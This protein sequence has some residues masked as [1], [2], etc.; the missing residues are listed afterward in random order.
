MAQKQAVLFV[1][2]TKNS[3]SIKSFLR[4]FFKKEALG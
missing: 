2:G 4:L 3:H 1:K